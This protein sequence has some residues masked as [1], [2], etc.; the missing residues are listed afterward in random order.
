MFVSAAAPGWAPRTVSNVFTYDM[1]S[2]ALSVSRLSYAAFHSLSDTERRG[3]GCSV[4]SVDGGLGADMRGSLNTLV[5]G[6]ADGAG[7]A[8]WRRPKSFFHDFCVMV[9]PNGSAK[10][11]APKTFWDLFDLLLS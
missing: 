8:A 9:G 6:G 4:D 1:T 7:E 10:I 11:L 5:N 3:V 2:S